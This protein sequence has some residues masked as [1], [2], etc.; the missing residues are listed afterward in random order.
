MTKTKLTYFYYCKS[1][2]DGDIKF[3]NGAVIDNGCDDVMTFDSGS[4]DVM[5]FDG[6]VDVIVNLIAVEGIPADCNGT[7]IK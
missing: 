7:E 5:T 2:L 1:Y 4:D 3:D 6:I